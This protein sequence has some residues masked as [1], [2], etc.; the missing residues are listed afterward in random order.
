MLY[1]AHRAILALACLFYP[2]VLLAEVSDKEPNA[3]LFWQVGLAAF[4]PWLGAICFTPAAIWFT[5]LFLEIHSPD[6][7]PYLRLEQGDGYYLQAYAAFALALSGLVTGC[8]WH[9][10]KSS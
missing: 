1:S 10:R 9:R 5:S 8:L 3:V 4:R 2:T 6:V 7:G